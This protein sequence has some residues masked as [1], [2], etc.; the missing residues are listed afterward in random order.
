MPI[1]LQYPA[2]ELLTAAL[3]IISYAMWPFGYDLVGFVLLGLWLMAVVLLIALAV[4]DVRWMLLP[5]KLV[6]PLIAIG[7]VFSMLR[8]MVVEDLNLI[9]AVLQISLGIISVGGL[10]YLLYAVSHHRWVGFGDVKLGIFIGAILGWKAG[11]LSVVIANFVGLMVI[12]PGLLTGKL[13]RTSKVPFGPFLIVG[14]VVALLFG[15]RA[16]DWYLNGLIL[17]V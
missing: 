14:C 7:L 17:G 2:V 1:S 10:Y 15:E 16:I 3:F 6:F 12:A 5:D 9:E 4:Y 13:S 11:L 8:F